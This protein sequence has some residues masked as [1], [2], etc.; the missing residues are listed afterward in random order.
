MF[1]TS[2]ETTRI[3][4]A[5]YDPSSGTHLRWGPWSLGSLRSFAMRVSFTSP[6][7]MILAMSFH[8]WKEK[9]ST[10]KTGKGH[11]EQKPRDSTG[12]WV[13]VGYF[14]YHV[15]ITLYFRISKIV[16][17][18]RFGGGVG[19]G[20]AWSRVMSDKSTHLVDV[21]GSHWFVSTGRKKASVMANGHL[22]S[23][24]LLWL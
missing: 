3:S 10:V 15:D 4:L 1:L 11:L 20:L 13:L 19:W 12:L 18:S 5:E 9:Q 16:Y 24:L 6:T 17:S 14:N 8:T 23:F 2:H 21:F 22:W 7:P